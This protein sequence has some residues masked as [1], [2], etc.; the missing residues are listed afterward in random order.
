MAQSDLIRLQ[1]Y[2]VLLRQMKLNGEDDTPESDKI[3]DK[4]DVWWYNLT[5]FER[6][7]IK[8]FSADLIKYIEKDVK[9]GE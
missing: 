6:V 9:L 7:K 3:R 5:F 4:M 8:T 1:Y 2:T